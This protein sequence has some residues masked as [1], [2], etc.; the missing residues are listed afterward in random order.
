MSRDR[1]NFTKI[2]LQLE[3]GINYPSLISLNN[4]NLL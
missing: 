2:V 4:A 3:D 1:L